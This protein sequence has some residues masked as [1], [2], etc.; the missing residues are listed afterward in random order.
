VIDLG[1]SPGLAL[2]VVLGLGAGLARRP[3]RAWRRTLHWSMGAAL[4]LV[5]TVPLLWDGPALNLGRSFALRGLLAGGGLGRMED[6]TRAVGDLSVAA[7]KDPLDPGTWYLLAETQSA[8]GDQQAAVHALERGVLAD[9][10]NPMLRYAALRGL[11]QPEAARDW[12]G[13]RRVYTQW[14]AR[15]P[16][17]AQWYVADAMAACVGAGDGAAAQRSLV[18]GVQAHAQPAQLLE[19]YRA[20]MQHCP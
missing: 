11:A 19:A 20:E 7:A 2:W 12:G 13:L 14:M 6:L 3:R 9:S 4:M 17:V 16:A 10:L 8:R 5:L 18:A 15:Y 1:E